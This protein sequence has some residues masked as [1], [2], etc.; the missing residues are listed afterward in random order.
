MNA[1]MEHPQISISAFG[2]TD[3]GRRRQTNEDAFLLTDLS[4]DASNA[5]LLNTNQIGERGALLIVADGMGGTEAGE[6][7]SALAVS[8]LHDGLQLGEVQQAASE[9]LRQMTERANACIRQHAQRSSQ[10]DGMGTTLTAALVRD[11]IAYLAQIGDSRA[12]LIRGQ[13]IRQLTKD[14]SYVQ[15]MVDDGLLSPEEA[16]RHPYRNVIM[17]ALGVESDIKVALTAIALQRNDYLLLCSDG[18]S[19]YVTSEEMLQIVQGAD[20]PA[21][22]CRLLTEVANARGGEDNITVIVAQFAGD[23]LYECGEGSLTGRLSL[24]AKAA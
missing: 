23:G 15:R 17:Q 3:I 19:G 13:S 22:A 7:A 10:L 1:N 11:G 6:V 5:P 16:A 18:L 20:S 8:T 9:Q 21:Y 12:Y 24:L 4:G 2:L 14:Q